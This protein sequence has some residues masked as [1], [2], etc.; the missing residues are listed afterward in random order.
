MRATARS[1]AVKPDHAANSKFNFAHLDAVKWESFVTQFLKQEHVPGFFVVKL[2][3][4]GGAG[5]APLLCWCWVDVVP[6]TR[7]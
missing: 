2:S 4:R 1:L 7:F 6:S 3:V 5:A